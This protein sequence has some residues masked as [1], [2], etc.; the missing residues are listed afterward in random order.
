METILT[1]MIELIKNSTDGITAERRLVAYFSEWI[2]EITG[3]AL[4]CMDDALAEEYKKTGYK[5]EKRDTRTIQV[6]FGKVNFKRRRMK[7]AGEKALYPLDKEMGFLKGE[8]FSPLLLRNI[9]EVASGTVLRKTEQ[10][11]SLLTPFSISHTKVKSVLD[12]V[13]SLQKNYTENRLLDINQV[14]EPKHKKKVPFLF[15]EGDGLM[16]KATKKKRGEIHRIQIA[17]GVEKN[18]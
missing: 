12:K 16:Y 9:A 10:A 3:E 6:L 11:V 18:G 4:E 14:E 8:A 5:I 15:I 1:E 13:G 7:K 2:S 17:E